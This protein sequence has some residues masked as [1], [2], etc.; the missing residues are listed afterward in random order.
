MTNLVKISNKK[1]NNTLMDKMEFD[2]V[3]CRKAEQNINEAN[4]N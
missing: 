3:N 1:I 4:N 2:S